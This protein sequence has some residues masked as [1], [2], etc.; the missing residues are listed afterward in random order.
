MISVL[1]Y[2]KKCKSTKVQR[3]YIIRVSC[4]L[5]C[6]SLKF[7]FHSCECKLIFISIVIL[8]FT[9]IQLCY[10]SKKTQA[11]S[12]NT[13]VI[14]LT[15]YK[16]HWNRD[17]RDKENVMYLFLLRTSILNDG[18]DVLSFRSP[19]WVKKDKNWVCANY[20][21]QEKT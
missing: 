10:M 3:Q 1:G 13:Q 21:L 18:K 12:Q 11:D 4:L 7:L 17:L 8:K 15:I 14:S 19:S 20:C 16:G 2:S 6:M 5:W 9:D